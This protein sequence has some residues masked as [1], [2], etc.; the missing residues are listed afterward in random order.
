MHRTLQNLKDSENK[1]EILQYGSI[2]S[3]ATVCSAGPSV[4]CHWAYTLDMKIS[5]DF[6]SASQM[7][8][9]S[10]LHC[11]GKDKNMSFSCRI[12]H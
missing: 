7:Q 9:L 2:F 8:Q 5:P 4:S 10:L 3:A 11:S 6:G 1:K 12:N